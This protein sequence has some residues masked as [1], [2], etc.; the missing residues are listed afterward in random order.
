MFS[1]EKLSQAKQKQQQQIGIISFYSSASSSFEYKNCM[2]KLSIKT[3]VQRKT[4]AEK[5]KI[6]NA[7][8]F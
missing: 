2:S 8:E 6:T 5:P 3:F 1:E 7:S 4:I